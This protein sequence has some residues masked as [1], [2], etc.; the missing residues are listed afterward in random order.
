MLGVG[1]GYIVGVFYG[2]YQ[3]KAGFTKAATKM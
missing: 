1:G 2:T 3:T